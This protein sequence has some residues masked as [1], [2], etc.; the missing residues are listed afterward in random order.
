M[1]FLNMSFLS[2]LGGRFLLFDFQPQG[3]H[4]LALC[5]KSRKHLREFGG[6]LN[7]SRLIKGL[8]CSQFSRSRRILNSIS[9]V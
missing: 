3:S 4:F 5:D 1:S 9:G 6:G 2:S 7:C 8:S